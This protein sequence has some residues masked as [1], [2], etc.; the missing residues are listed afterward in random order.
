[1][2]KGKILLRILANSLLGVI[3]VF[4][5][6]R[7]VN[8]NEVAGILRK[9]DIKFAIFFFVFFFVSGTLRSIRFKLMLKSYK[10]PLK[11]VMMLNFLSQFLSFMIPIRAG[12]IA[13][14]AYLTSQF[15]LPLG[16]SVVWVFVDR[17][18]D[19]WVV[20][21]LISV[22]LAFVSNNLPAHSFQ[23]VLLLFIIFS[24]VFVLALTC[25]HFFKRLLGKIKFLTFAFTIIEGFGVLRRRPLEFAPLIVLSFLATLSD[26]MAWGLAFISLGANPDI[27]KVILGNCLA[28]LTFLIPAAPGYVGS[29]EAAGLAV[30]SGI[31]G[32]NANFVSAA[33]VLYHIL[34]IVVILVLGVGSLYFLK[35]DL[36][37]VWKKLKK[38]D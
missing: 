13:K 11:D 19:F 10:L 5:W 9:V 7:F 4:V 8:L 35:F 12:E 29:A 22:F 27:L 26:S 1:M 36:K 17:F 24:L 15:D 28:A 33:T 38:Q 14:S 32:L 25:E 2:L 3:L 31:L 16:K 21:L 34:T 37:L 20:L 6:T 23:L 18:L 30:F